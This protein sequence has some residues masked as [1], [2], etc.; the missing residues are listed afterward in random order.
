MRKY[1]FL[2]FS[3]LLLF[4]AFPVSSQE[5]L[6]GNSCFDE[7]LYVMREVVPSGDYDTEG[8]WMLLLEPD[9]GAVAE[10]KIEDGIL[11]VDIN[12][13]GPNTWSVQIL[14]SP[15]TIEKSG[16]YEGSFSAKASE[17]R[18]IGLKIGGTA[19]RGWLAY[20]PGEDQSGGLVFELTP[21]W[22]TYNFSFIMRRDTD[23]SARFEFQLGR[24]AG[25]VFLDGVILKKVGVAIAK[26]KPPKIYTEEDEDK[27]E[28]WQL[29]F[30]EEFDHSEINGSIWNFEL[31]N[32]HEN[33]I[34]GWGNAELEYYTEENAFIED[35]C[36]IIEAREEKR[37]DKYG[38]YDYTSSRMTTQGK[39]D[40]AYGKIEVRAKLPRGQGIWPAIWMLG[41][42]IS[43][44][45]WPNCGEIDV[46]EFLGHDTRTVYGTAHG[47]GFSGSGGIGMSYKLPEEE[48]DFSED[49]HIFALEWDEDEIEWYVDGKLYHVLSKD[50][51]EDAAGPEAWVFDKP[52]F[53]ILNVA[54]GGYWPG[55][56]DETTTFPQRM[57]IDYIRVYEDIN[58]EKIEDEM[59]DCEYEIQERQKE[60]AAITFEEIDNGTFDEPIKNDQA[61]D[62][63]NWFIWYGLPYGMSGEVE[64]FGIEKGVFWIKLKDL[65]EESWHI[66]FNQYV[67]LIPGREYKLTFEARADEGRDINVK[68]LHPTTY[69]IYAVE[70]FDLI[71]N[72]QKY[73]LSF[74]LPA[75]AYEIVNLSFELGKVSDKSKATTVYFDNIFIER[76]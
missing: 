7:P 58:P 1:I 15:I 12:N 43:E 9:S 65:G 63:N 55:Y 69:Q 8:T 70:S 18:N 30:S 35:G 40:F 49:F 68:L 71:E 67:R 6:L 4:F 21:E 59:D 54:V 28:D 60:L 29:V 31:G 36:L 2:L 11:V 13:G 27:T 48:K 33:G 45:G 34:P 47:P 37:S 57:Y 22:K 64:S 44:V 72:M 23:N 32:G 24:D 14:Q 50:E 75:D 41:E 42:N 5:N 61:N 46:M 76:K 73:E 10:A 66:Q 62:P 51:V 56:P 20:N 3:F 19:G 39:F 52:F 17:K 74:A 25:T 38:S 53:L 26:E 16:I